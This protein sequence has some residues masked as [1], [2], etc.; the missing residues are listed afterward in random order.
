MRVIAGQSR[1]TKLTA[2]PGLLTRPTSD[3][4][5]EALFSILTSRSSFGG[6]R[7]LDICAG[8][9]ALGIEAL[10][11]GAAF[12]TFVEH[13]RLLKGILA[14][15]I[16]SARVE[17]CTEVLIQ[18]ARQALATLSAGGR[19]FDLVFFDPPY[20]SGLYATIPGK[21]C[22]CGLLAPGSLLV[23][24]CSARAPLPMPAAPLMQCDRRVYG[25]TALEL[26]TLEAP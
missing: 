8:S 2:P 4:V 23:I 6:L 14:K 1:G 10:S 5:K 9:G 7:V 12:C 26:F 25:D 19:M 13:D 20:S 15:N 16:S 3:R 22:S 21:L 24:E 18:D 17:S 11:R